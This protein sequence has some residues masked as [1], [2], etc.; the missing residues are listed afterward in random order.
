MPWAR[1]ESSKQFEQLVST[2][3]VLKSSHTMTK[4]SPECIFCKIVAGQIPSQKVFEDADTLAFLDIKPVNNGHTLVIPKIH[5]PYF[6]DLDN[7]NYAKLMQTVKNVSRAIEHAVKPAKVG[8]LVK[9]FD[10]DHAH[11]HVIPLNNNAD[12]QATTFSPTDK[13]LAETAENLRKGIK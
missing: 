2:L 8:L 12:I 6:Y 10:V 1:F 5:V 7:K 11:I 3:R 4:S 9:G 13:Q